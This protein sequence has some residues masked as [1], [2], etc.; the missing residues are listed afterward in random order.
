MGHNPPVRLVPLVGP[1]ADLH[2]RPIPDGLDGPEVW[3][4]EPDRPGL[5]LGSAQQESVADLGATALAGVEVVRRRSGGGAVYVAPQR[6]LWL[7]V[8][9]PRHDSR[10]NDDVRES[11]VWLGKAW[12][13]ALASLG[14]VGELHR[15]GLERTPWGRLV[16]FAAVGPGEVLLD[17]RKLVG[18][19]QRR[20]REGARF[21]CIVYD[22]WDPY[23]VLDLLR[24]SE[25]DRHRVAAELGDVAAGVGE[26]LPDLRTAI[27][28]ELLGPDSMH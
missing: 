17:G 4:F 7:D 25:A 24:M 19:S 16:C 27:L 26:R 12:R 3:L 5:V 8:V 15:G 10:W 20:T 6:C 18:I 11:T 1:I 13:A 14:L 21:Q 22:R 2:A 9:L 23:D 28:R